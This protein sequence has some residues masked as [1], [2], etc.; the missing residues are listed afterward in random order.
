VVDW[1]CEERWELANSSDSVRGPFA[2]RGAKEEEE[3]P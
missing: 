1:P 2:A 3:Y